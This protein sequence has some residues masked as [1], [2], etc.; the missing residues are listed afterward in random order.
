MQ[1]HIVHLDMDTFFVSVERLLNSNLEGKPILIG[2]SSD[3][4]V[5]ASCSYEARRFGVHSAMPMRMALRLCPESIVIRGD[6]DS[7][8]RYSRMVTEIL[9]E[10]APVVEKAS[11]DEHYLDLTGMDKLFGCYKWSAELRQEIIRQTGLPISFGL[12]PNKTVSKIATGQAKPNGEK[13]IN[14]GSEKSFLAPLSIRKIPMLGDMTFQ[15]LRNMKILKVGTIQQMP[16]DFMHRI[17]GENG[18]M[19]WQKANGID[20]SPVVPYRESKSMSKEETFETDTTDIQRLRKT[21]IT[22]TD[23]LGFELRKEQRLASC[24]V[25]KIRYSNWDT[26]TMQ[27]RLPYTASDKLLVENALEL[28]DKIYTR[29]MG[30]RL[31]GVKFTGLICGS[32]QINLFEDAARDINLCKA[33]DSIRMRFGTDAVMKA[34]SIR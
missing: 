11:I 6:H 14:Y 16:A 28:F 5:V 1:R 12:S 25:I 31:L 3:R 8:S 30:I 32:Y 29:R 7:Y 18:I 22:M 19:I 24:L 27:C 21:I 34:I 9:E 15:K 10:N 26:H 17:L 4:G 23:K 2:G 20:N 13:H 33:M